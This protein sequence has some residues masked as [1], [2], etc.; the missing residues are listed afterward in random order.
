MNEKNTQSC[1]DDYRKELWGGLKTS[2]ENFDKA[3]LT[4]SGGGL[5]ISLTVIKD[6]FSVG[7]MVAGALLVASWFL[8]CGSI[9]FT[10]VSFLTSQKSITV[11]IDNFEKFTAGDV[12]YFNRPNP[13]TKITAWLN[14]ISGGFFLLAVMAMTF[15]TTI[16]FHERI[17]MSKELEK[18]QKGIVVPSMPLHQPVTEGL[19]PPQM[20][21]IPVN[22][23][24]QVSVQNP[25]PQSQTEKK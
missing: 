11:Q 21:S 3:V 23:V 4:L 12:S 7:E 15:F 24:N 19:R 20:P 1:Y 22:Q 10:V 9:I 14:Q 25:S 6:L 18:F 16:N 2:H 13:Y 5:A 8:F 17:S